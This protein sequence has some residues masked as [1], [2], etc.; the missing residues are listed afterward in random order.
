MILLHWP[1][2][3]LILRYL[4][5]PLMLALAAPRVIKNK[6]TESVHKFALESQGM[7]VEGSTVTLYNCGLTPKIN[8][9]QFGCSDKSE[10]SFTCFEFESFE[11]NSRFRLPFLSKQLKKMLW[12]VISPYGSFHIAEY[13]SIFCVPELNAEWRKRV[14]RRKKLWIEWQ[15]NR[16][17]YDGCFVTKNENLVKSTFCVGVYAERHDDELE[18]VFDID[19]MSYKWQFWWKSWISAGFSWNG[20]IH[21]WFIKAFR[22]IL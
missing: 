6:T 22:W 11:R 19:W 20:V 14:K 18:K 17:L 10:K 21:G 5:T 12:S 7:A 9:P 3:S 13:E 2:Q 1:G 8:A 4:R 15:P 16:S